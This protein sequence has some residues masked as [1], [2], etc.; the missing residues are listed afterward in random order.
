VEDRQSGRISYRGEVYYM[1][2]DEYIA[3][4]R[5]SIAWNRGS[6]AITSLT[7]RRPSSRIS[8]G[9]HVSFTTDTMA[10]TMEDP[11]HI[12]QTNTSTNTTSTAEEMDIESGLNTTTNYDNNSN[13][14]GNTRS[15]QLDDHSVPMEVRYIILIFI[16]NIY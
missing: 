11:H 7:T 13:Y 6:R 4:A 1:V 16:L 8:T 3:T 9:R 14:E 15:N 2:P 12:P 10:D 5:S